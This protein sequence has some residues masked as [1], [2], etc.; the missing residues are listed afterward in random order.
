MPIVAVSVLS[1][2]GVV[3]RRNEDSVSA[4]PWTL[5]ATSAD[6]PQT[7]Y[8]PLGDTPV[9]VAV[10][11][12]LGGHPGGDLA[13]SLVVSQLAATSAELGD[14]QAVEDAL[15]A[16]HTAVHD[17]AATDPGLAGM[18]TTVAGLTVTADAVLVFNVGDSRV[19]RLTDGE[20]EL[21]STD[22]SP[23]LAPGWRTTNLVTRTL[24]G[25]TDREAL[26]PHLRRLPLRTGARYLL[27]TD[28]LSDPVPAE[29]WP[30]LIVDPDGDE[31][32]QHAVVELWRAAIRAGGPDNITLALVRIED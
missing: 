15:L 19:Y 9:T 27:C 24:G 11:D 6:S 31:D 2:T 8:F 28:G 18:A 12:G 21:L 4:G 10:A 7:L 20:P 5:C 23:P 16:C 30:E 17:A 3:R 13:S 14:E 1:H 26:D 32:D 22:D 25:A 29:E